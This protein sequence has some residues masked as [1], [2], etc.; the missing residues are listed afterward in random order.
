[1]TRSR[2]YLEPNT[3]CYLCS[4][5]IEKG[6]NWNRDHIPPSRFFGSALKKSLNPQLRWLPTHV[7]CNSS[8]RR[9]EELFVLNAVFMAAASESEAADSLLADIRRGLLKGQQHGLFLSLDKQ[10]KSSGEPDETVVFSYDGE[11]TLRIIWKIVRGLYALEMGR[12]LHVD[13]A[14]HCYPLIGP[15]RSKEQ[16]EKIEWLV[17]VV[18]VG[19]SFG[20]YKQVLDYRWLCFLDPDQPSLRVHGFALLLWD[21]VIA[22][23]LIHDPTC[24]CRQCS[25]RSAAP[26]PQGPAS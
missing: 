16:I 19:Q 4:L 17:D 6:Q 15:H 1:M 5:P 9:D 25:G 8:Y 3:A 14:H 11:R 21:R 18:L 22:P 23:V 26:G 12:P 2:R 7:E 10:F 13:T 20:Q 24:G